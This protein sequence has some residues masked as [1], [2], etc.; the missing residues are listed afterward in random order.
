MG[1]PRE[2]LP[3]AGLP[4][5]VVRSRG[6][7]LVAGKGS[8]ITLMIDGYEASYLAPEGDYASDGVVLV[9]FG[10]DVLITA[11][12]SNVVVSN[13]NGTGEAINGDSLEFSHFGSNST[14]DVRV[15][16]AQLSDSVSTLI[17]LLEVGPVTGNSFN[18]EIADSLL[19]NTN[20]R[21]NVEPASGAIAYLKVLFGPREEE[22]VDTLNLTVKDTKMSG[23][24]RGI[25][26]VNL[27]K[28]PIKKMNILV[29]KSSLSD[30]KEEGFR[31]LNT[32]DIGSVKIDLG[33]GPLGSS[34]HN[35]FTNNGSYDVSVVNSSEMTPIGVFASK[36]FWDGVAPTK[37]DVVGDVEF[38]APVFLTEDPNY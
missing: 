1:D 16:H 6:L 20:P 37:V 32:A 21:A 31:V 26:I 5:E 30:M 34:G 33:K 24:M 7:T 29:E 14:L 22:M 15:K 38:F 9:T 23:H 11:D 2:V 27:N 13:P 35:R 12:I 18:V 25:N 8:H 10:S 36:N 17:K 4:E 19:T 28:V 3:D